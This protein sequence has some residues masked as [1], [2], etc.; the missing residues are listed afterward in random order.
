[1][2]VEGYIDHSDARALYVRGDQGQLYRFERRDVEDIDH[3]GNVALTVGTT[4][5]LLWG[6]GFASLAPEDRE[7]NAGLAAVLFASL[8]ALI[9]SGGYTY[10]RSK[11]AARN[12]EEGPRYLRLGPAPTGAR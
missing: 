4:F 10:F 3:P 11:G 2:E 6:V 9:A 5:G 12:F 8:A 7:K 1:M